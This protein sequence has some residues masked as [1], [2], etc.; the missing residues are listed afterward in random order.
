MGFGV[1]YF[2]ALVKYQGSVQGSGLKD[3]GIWA[4]H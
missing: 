3:S 1:E 4:A 2:Q